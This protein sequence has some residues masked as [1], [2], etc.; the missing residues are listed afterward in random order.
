[1]I[2][3]SKAGAN[4]TNRSIIAVSLKYLLLFRHTIEHP[5]ELR[6][7]ICKLNV[8]AIS[9]VSLL[10]AHSYEHGVCH[11]VK[12]RSE[13]SNILEYRNMCWC[14]MSCCKG[15]C[16]E[17]IK[18]KFIIIFPLSPFPYKGRKFTK[19]RFIFATIAP[20]ILHWHQWFPSARG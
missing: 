17:R 19:R 1:M 15:N 10:R 8:L 11:S 5:K 4:N 9:A 2:F 7:N 18:G 13:Y 14:S 3:D 6:A 20:Y 16:C 12:Y